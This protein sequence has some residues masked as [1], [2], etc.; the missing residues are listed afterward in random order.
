MEHEVAEAQV[1]VRRNP[2][3]EL[4]GIAGQDEAGLGVDVLLL[5]QSLQLERVVDA[6]LALG[7][8]RQGS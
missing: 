2:V 3:A 4:I 7:R 1:D 8:Q 5:G 6:L